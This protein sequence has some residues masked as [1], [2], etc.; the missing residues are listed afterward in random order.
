MLMWLKIRHYFRFKTLYGCW[1]AF[2]KNKTILITSY[3]EN[4]NKKMKKIDN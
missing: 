1:C 2:S 4:N 3:K